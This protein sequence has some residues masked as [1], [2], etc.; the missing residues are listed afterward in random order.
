M[1]RKLRVGIIGA[2]GHAGGELCRLL[3]RHPSVQVIVPGTR[4]G[5]LF[6]RVHPNLLGCGLE[7]VDQ[8][9][10]LSDPDSFDVVFFCAPAGEA[11]Q[12][13]EIF[14]KA[15]CRVID[16]GPDF[17]FPSPEQYEAVYGRPHLAQHLLPDAI[18]GA[19][20]FFRTEIKAARL[21]AN[22]GCYAFTSLLA[23]MPAL[24]SGLVDTAQDIFVSAVNGSTGAS[25][26]PAR[27]TSHAMLANGMLDYSMEGHRHGP[28][29]EWH[30]EVISGIPFR[31]VL[32]T[33][34]G[35]FPRGIHLIATWRPLFMQREL[36]RELLSQYYLKAYGAGVSGERFV[37]SNTSVREGAKTEKEYHLYPNL[38]RVVGSNF[39]HL[40]VDYDPVRNQC[41][42]VA[43][44][45]NLGKGAAGTAIQNLNVMF[46]LEEATA[47]SAFGL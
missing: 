41:K 35:S 5:A 45:D 29:I 9:A 8:R 32:S 30:G 13:A 39:C 44:I 2:S 37:V 4:S 10:I 15:G 36:S 20:E 47:I 46:D 6:E 26:L 1:N 21:V 17:R 7:F 34:H 16:L 25:S 22:P 43:V 11:M 18:Y 3:L 31:C 23:L 27:D 28:E 42:V 24:R 38:A 14:L 19:T 33:T 12:S 40:A